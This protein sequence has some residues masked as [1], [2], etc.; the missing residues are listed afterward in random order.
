M[1]GFQPEGGFSSPSL[2]FLPSFLPFCYRSPASLVGSRLC[3]ALLCCKN[4]DTDEYEVVENS[5]FVV[6]R[7]VSR[8]TSGTE[9]RVNGQKAQQRQVVEL[10][11]SK[12]LDLQNNRF[13]ILQGEV[14]QI[15]LMKP[16][17]SVSE[18]ERALAFFFFFFSCAFS[19]LSL[20]ALM[21]RKEDGE[22][23]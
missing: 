2:L 23:D 1:P 6:S 3:S 7:E 20:A 14:E 12:G 15:S 11:K 10:L 19:S 8:L 18:L 17:A 5:Q 16:K 9:Y 22:Y 13:L 4:P 21:R